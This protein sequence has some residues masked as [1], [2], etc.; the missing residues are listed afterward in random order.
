DDHGAVDEVYASAAVRIAG[1]FSWRTAAVVGRR[2]SRP[3]SAAALAAAASSACVRPSVSR[4]FV[5]FVG[6]AGF[7]PTAPRSQSEC[8]TKLRH[9]RWRTQCTGSTPPGA[10]AAARL[11]RYHV[12]WPRLAWP[13]AAV[14]QW[15][16]FSLPN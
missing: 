6:V 14:A 1:A 9:T 16:S 4:T 8:A 7:D 13:F 5:R 10:A 15:Q 3:R 11:T 12:R 2:R